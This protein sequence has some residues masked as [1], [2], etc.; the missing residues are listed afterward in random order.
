LPLRTLR[1]AA[2]ALSHPRETFSQ[3]SRI[4]TGFVEAVSASISAASPT[5]LNQ[6]IGPHRRFDWTRFDLGEVKA[7]GKRLGGTINDVVLA[8]VAG[9]VRGYLRSH[10]EDVD[11]IDFRAFV[12]VSTR[13][14]AERGKLGNRVS[15][16]V[17]RL[18]VC[19]RDAARRM[20]RVI[21]ETRH[22]KE[23]SQVVGTEVIEELSD[24][25]ST[26][27][28]T[29]FSRTAAAARSYNLV[30]TNVPGPQY[31]VYMEGAKMLASYPLVPL[32]ENQVLGIALLSYD[33]SLFWGFNADWD[34]MPDL[35]AF[36][37]AIERELA[38]L[39]ELPASASA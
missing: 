28:L 30:V 4:A 5:P 16:L 37:E 36:V 1:A 38:S 32:F 26:A 34:L 33:G 25:T 8:C 15:M 39:R 14:S 17:A 20:T 2:P 19:E 13:A 27:V 23:S 11:G 10:G 18:P 24:W 31:A 22:L 9:A 6:P 35:H 3:A 21:E 7:I 12:P 29:A